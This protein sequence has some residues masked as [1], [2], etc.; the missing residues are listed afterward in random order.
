MQH[1]LQRCLLQL[2]QLSLNALQMQSQ[3]LLATATHMDL[4]VTATKKLAKENPVS[5]EA[6]FSYLLTNYDASEIREM[7]RRDKIATRSS[8]E[9]PPQIP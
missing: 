8:S 2:R 9:S 1:Q 7:P 4:A 5:F 3:Q 6:G